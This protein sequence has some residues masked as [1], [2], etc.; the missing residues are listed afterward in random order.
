MVRDDKGV[1]LTMLAVDAIVDRVIAIARRLRASVSALR[2]SFTYGDHV[3]PYRAQFSAR[4]TLSISVLPNGAVEVVAPLGTP[5]REIQSRLKRRAHWI[6]RQ[7]RYFSQFQP[8]T[9]ERRFI[10]GET[11]L[12]LGRQYR[13]KCTQGEA[14]KVTLHGGLLCIPMP[15]VPAQS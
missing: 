8:R 15:L 6:A 11:H 5:E 10:S 12:Y 13:L 1:P 7:P 4:R 3:V 14:E 9:P 2:G